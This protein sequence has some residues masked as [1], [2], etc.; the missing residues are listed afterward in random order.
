LPEA[1]NASWHRTVRGELTQVEAEERLTALERAPLASVPLEQDIPEA[2]RLALQLNPPVY[3]S[4][5]LALAKR[6]GTLLRRRLH[7]LRVAPLVEQVGFLLL[8][9][10]EMRV[11]HVAVAADV[12]GDASEL[13][14]EGVV[15]G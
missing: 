12:V 7:R 11:L 8:G 4:L 13:D 1:G 3:E 14:G 6:L 15:L 9:L 5:Y 2:M 10:R